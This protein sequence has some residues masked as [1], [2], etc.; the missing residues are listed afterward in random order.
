MLLATTIS[1]C[2]TDA[3]AV[4]LTSRANPTY[5]TAY[6]IPRPVE[7]IAGWEFDMNADH[8]LAG[9]TVPPE[10]DE[11][12]Y[13]PGSAA[14]QWDPLNPLETQLLDLAPV[15]S[16]RNYAQEEIEKTIGKTNGVW[17]GIEKTIRVRAVES[18]MEHALWGVFGPLVGLLV[19]TFIAGKVAEKRRKSAMLFGLRSAAASMDSASFKEMMST[20]G[21]P[22]WAAERDTERPGWANQVIY[23]SGW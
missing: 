10:N 4:E 16:I 7:K 2:P 1:L 20:L 11:S 14:D 8:P 6:E 23:S 15:W 21:L 9:Y 17:G 5:N 13:P 12:E 22:P 19:G 3:I 18:I